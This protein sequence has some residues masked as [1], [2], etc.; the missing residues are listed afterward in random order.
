[1]VNVINKCDLC[2]R[3]RPSLKS[4]DAI[5]TKAEYPMEKVAV[6]LFQWENSHFLVMVDRYSG[7]P[8]IKKVEKTY[9]VRI[10]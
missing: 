5:V 10:L 3:Y 8:W 4:D 6:D 9:P 2:Q 1:M 7:Y